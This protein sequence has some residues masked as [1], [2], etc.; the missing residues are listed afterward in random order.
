MY[1]LSDRK[2]ISKEQRVVRYLGTLAASSGVISRNAALNTSPFNTTIKVFPLKLLVP[3]D[4]WVNPTRLKGPWEWSQPAKLMQKPEGLQGQKVGRKWCAFPL[5][6]RM[7]QCV[8]IQH[9][10]FFPSFSSRDQQTHLKAERM[11]LNRGHV[12]GFKPQT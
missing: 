1:L 6:V 2:Q 12:N 9:Y 11:C 4:K 3:V 7:M 10:F 8:V 5:S